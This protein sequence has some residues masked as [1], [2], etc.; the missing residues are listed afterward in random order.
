MSNR[1][2]IPLHRLRRAVRSL[3]GLPALLAL[4]LCPACGSDDTAGT[5]ATAGEYY[6]SL[7][8]TV[9]TGTA[10]RATRVTSG[11]NGGEEGDGR[12]E[13]TAAENRVTGVTI[14]LFEGQGI[15]APDASAIT[16]YAFYW[17][18]T[19][20]ETVPGTRAV[21]Y[22]TGSRL[23][24]KR[25]KSGHYHLL[26][27][28]NADRSDLDGKMLSEVR[29]AIYDR[30]PFTPTTATA[31][32]AG[33]DFV[34][35]SAADAEIMIGPVQGGHAGTEQDPY[36]PGTITDGGYADKDVD[37]ERLAARID[38]D[39]DGST[40]FTESATDGDGYVYPVIDVAAGQA[41]GETFVLTAVVPFNL[42]TPSW[43]FKRVAAP[44]AVSAVSWLGDEHP[45]SGVQTNYVVGLYF[46]DKA[47]SPFPHAGFY[48]PAYHRATLDAALTAGH[49]VPKGSGTFVVAYTAEN[50]FPAAVQQ[51]ETLMGDVATGLRFIGYI[52]DA[53]GHKTEDRSYDYYLRHSDPTGTAADDAVMKYGVV[54]NNIYCVRISRVTGV[55]MDFGIRLELRVVP[56][57]KYTHPG[58]IM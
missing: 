30:T 50:T 43:L 44:E 12:E 52:R 8:I 22:T 11:P 17:P 36:Q 45:A 33:T 1:L 48:V 31:V 28:A 4:A 15:N 19:R 6:L 14:F 23:L 13:G 10:T 26:A 38:F 46:G 53:G 40:G 49:H 29:D 56:W 18:V 20:D 3:I 51:S 47:T 32:V 24:D 41:T 21:T 25:I 37:V 35:A 5:A 39:T 42:A 27:V 58:L 57:L 34:M 54:R 9:S 55:Q 7:N 16:V 2:H